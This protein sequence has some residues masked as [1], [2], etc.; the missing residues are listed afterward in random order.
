M[1]SK[2]V[3]KQVISAFKTNKPVN[4]PV[5]GVCGRIQKIFPNSPEIKLEHSRRQTVFIFG[6]D[7]IQN[8][9]SLKSDFERLL[10]TKIK[11]ILSG[12]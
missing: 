8:L 11:T 2:Q 3:I 10:Y 5:L 9:C 12:V 6:S 1:S 7:G 4:V